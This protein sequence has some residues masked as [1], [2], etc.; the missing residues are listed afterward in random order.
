MSTKKN[1]DKKYTHYRKESNVKGNGK[2]AAA[3]VSLLPM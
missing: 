1:I 2:P 3:A